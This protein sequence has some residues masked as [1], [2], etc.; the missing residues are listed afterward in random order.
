M[1]QLYHS[2]LFALVVITAIVCGTGCRT[3]QPGGIYD[4]DDV[5][6]HAE[7]TIVTSYAMVDTFLKWEHE[8]RALLTKW[9]EAKQYADE[10]RQ[11]YPLWYRTANNLRDAYALTREEST[12]T[13]LS[14]YLTLLR[15][16]LLEASAY[17][18]KPV[19]E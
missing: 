19:S 15:T 5:L 9:P 17:M 6:F 10:L 12:A 14:K 13:E 4:G 16:A 18:T 11:N 8:N 3:L 1:K 7:T 2:G